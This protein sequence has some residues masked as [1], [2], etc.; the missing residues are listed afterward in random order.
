MAELIAKVIFDRLKVAMRWSKFD[1]PGLLGLKTRGARNTLQS[2]LLRVTAPYMF[3]FVP[4]RS[5]ARH[6]FDRGKA[7]SKPSNPRPLRLR[8]CA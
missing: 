2:S 1:N 5:A 4:E 7:A 3:G 6:L 8:L